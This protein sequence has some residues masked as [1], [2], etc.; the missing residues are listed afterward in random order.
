MLEEVKSPI[1][2]RRPDDALQWAN[3][4]NVKRPWRYSIFDYYAD[5]ILQQAAHGQILEIGQDQAI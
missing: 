3:E 5:E 4:A 1:D 2:L